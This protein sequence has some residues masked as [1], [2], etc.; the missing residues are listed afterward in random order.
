MD[1]ITRAAWG[2]RAPSGTI[3][4]TTWA[5]RTGLVVHYSAASKDQTVRS[6]Q[7]YQMDVRGWSD[8]GYNFL[9]DHLGRLYEGRQGTWLAIGAH[10]AGHNTENIGVCAIGTD[11]DITDAQKH[12]IRWLYDEACRRADKTLVRRYHNL[13]A[14]NPKPGDNV[15]SCPG[16]NL[17]T[18]VRNGMPIDRPTPPPT[19]QPDWTTEII[20]NLP[21]LHRGNNGNAVRRLQGLLI[22]AGSSDSRVDGDFGYATERAVRREQAQAHITVDGIV[23]RQTWTKLLGA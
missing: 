6:I 4:N 23:G 15:T 16:D 10:V 5:S 21:T 9:V 11:A 14:N 12:A 17:R 7:N 3:H 2:A 22:A 1:I 19:P 13:Y 8:I 18:W 20:M